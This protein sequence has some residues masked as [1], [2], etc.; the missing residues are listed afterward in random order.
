MPLRSIDARAPGSG[1][2]KLFSFCVSIP[3]H[4]SFGFGRYR[5]I[6]NTES[7]EGHGCPRKIHGEIVIVVFW[8][9][10]CQ[11]A[12]S[13]SVNPVDAE[14]GLRDVMSRGRMPK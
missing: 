6:A 10:K 1:V 7:E 14:E 11:S 8:V 12:F 5:Q 2:V 9:N 4:S 13:Y 3:T